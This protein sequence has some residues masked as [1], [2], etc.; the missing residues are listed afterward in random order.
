MAA[1]QLGVLSVLDEALTIAIY[2]L[3][4]EHPRLV[5]QLPIGAEPPDHSPERRLLGCLY[6]CSHM[7]AEYRLSV[8][9]V[10]DQCEVDQVRSVT[11]GDYDE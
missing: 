11:Q 7:L 4:A 1:P 5:N 10:L 8:A 9:Q 2:A 6:H 3:I